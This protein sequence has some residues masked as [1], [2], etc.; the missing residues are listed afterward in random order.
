[1]VLQGNSPGTVGS[2]MTDQSA[3]LEQ[4]IRE[5]GDDLLLFAGHHNWDSLDAQSRERLERVFSDARHPLVYLSAHTHEGFWKRHRLHGGRELLELNVN[6]L[7]DWPIAYRQL[8]V[9][10]NPDSNTIQLRAG[11]KTAAA[12]VVIPDEKGLVSRWEDGACR[13]S[14]ADV[15]KVTANQKAVVRAHFYRR[16]SWRQA[17]Q[18][19][20]QRPRSDAWRRALYSDS[21]NTL[22]SAIDS[23]RVAADDFPLFGSALE[24]AS[25]LRKLCDGK[26][27]AQCLAVARNASDDTS[28]TYDR[29]SELF[30]NI[31]AT[32]NDVTEPKLVAYM[33]CIA[34]T[35]AQE[36]YALSGSTRVRAS[37]FS[38]EA[39]ARDRH[40]P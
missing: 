24:S 1:M 37:L 8:T 14:G 33:A 19:L 12:D 30:T 21:L 28:A 2:I 18:V 27:I 4:W 5:A 32:L 9:G 11:L 25:R 17:F 3:V 38:N 35:A 16:G 6:S 23:V 39:Q 26:P 29:W 20:I 13:D 31:Q 7:A 40:S 34:V 15:Q 22:R 36:D 10:Y